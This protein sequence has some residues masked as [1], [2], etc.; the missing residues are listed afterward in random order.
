MSKGGDILVVTFFGHA[1]IH[2]AETIKAELC[3]TV[4]KLTIEGANEFLLGGYGNFDLLAAK[5]V[6]E[7]KKIRPDIRSFLVIP[8]PDARYDVSLYDGTVYPSLENV[9]KK[10]AI[11]KRNEWMADSAD[12]VV[13]YV[14][15]SWGGAAAAL[16]YC[17]RKK[18][19]II[20]IREPSI[21][22]DL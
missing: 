2:D 17:L 14:V 7:A 16:K 8:Y 15:H 1:E 22:L 20:A 6:Y 4:E 12:V 21:P 9:P 11:S 3:K 5:V 18:K 13:S 10:L 19:R